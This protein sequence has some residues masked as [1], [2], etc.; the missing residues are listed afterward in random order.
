MHIASLARRIERKVRGAVFPGSTRHLRRLQR[1]PSGTLAH[2]GTQYGGW[3]V[4]RDLAARTIADN[5]FVLSAGAGEDLSFDLEIQRRFQCDILIVDPT[6]R[7]IRH[8][9]LLVAQ[10]ERRAVFPINNSPAA[11]Y[12]TDGVDFGKLHFLPV[13]LWNKSGTLKFWQPRDPNHVS[14]S[15][16]N[17]QRTSRFIEVE[18][19]TVSQ[20]A[21]EYGISEIPLLKLD[22][23]GAE[24]VVLEQLMETNLRPA[25]IAVEFDCISIPGPD[26]E[27][28]L[29]RITDLLVSRGYDLVHFDGHANCLFVRNR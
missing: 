9:Q 13:A 27:G 1:L 28:D 16:T 29:R 4:D 26:T 11:T 21:A 5:S 7:A 25:Q 17:L 12:D 10:Y 2:Y 20:I 3:W 22:I 15:A 24:L 19:K 8:F 18:A 6:P 23:E 14:H